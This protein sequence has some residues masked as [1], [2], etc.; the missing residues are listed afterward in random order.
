MR[1]AIEAGAVVGHLDDD[2]AALM[3]GLERD[4]ADRRL[5]LGNALVGHF[6]AVVEAVAHQVRQRVG[7]AFD[8]ALVEFRAL[9]DGLQFDLLVELL[10]QVAHHAREA[11]EH[12]RD[13]HHADRHH[14]FL[15][16]ARIA[17]ELRQAVVQALELHRVEHR[18][19]LR[20][21]GLGDHQFADQVDQL[22]HLVD[23]DADRGFGGAARGVA[24]RSLRS[25]RAVRRRAA[26]PRAGAGS[27]EESALAPRRFGGGVGRST[28]KPKESSIGQGGLGARLGAAAWRVLEQ[29]P[30]ARQRGGGAGSVGRISRR[31]PR[32]RWLGSAAARHQRS[33]NC[34]RR[35]RRLPM[36]MLSLRARN[37]SMPRSIFVVGIGRHA[38]DASALRFVAGRV[39]DAH[40]PV[41]GDLG[42]Q[43][44]NDGVGVGCALVEQEAEIEADGGICSRA[45][46]RATPVPPWMVLCRR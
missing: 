26:R 44:G 17:F 16:V 11:R 5:A 4:V 32:H 29:A 3:V 33:R 21:H 20:Q 39:G 40:R 35:R 9:A 43:V 22:V 38:Q 18:G 10:R 34:R 14:R 25:R 42:H 37:S 46:G 23:V 12:H 2:V 7:D 30:A 15:H 31:P 6:D 19:R 45:V 13:R 27:V 1:P 36:R 8:Q 41:F 28:K 24:R